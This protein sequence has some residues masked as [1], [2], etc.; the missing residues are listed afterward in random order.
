MA[1]S[2]AARCATVGSYAAG[3]A[4]DR[5]PQHPTFVG[6]SPALRAALRLIDCFAPHDS[7]P[8][9]I[10]GESGT[11]KS[12]AARALHLRSPRAGYVFHQ[13]ILAA[14]DD[15]LAASDLF[16]HLSGAYTDARQS[17]PGHFVSANGGTLFLDEI[18]KASAAVQRKLLHAVEHYE[19]WPVGADRAVR[20]NVRLVAATNV[21]LGQ[22]VTRGEFLPDLAARLTNFRIQLPALRE[23]REDI[24]DLVRQFVAMRAPRCGFPHRTP[25]VSDPLLRALQCADWPNNLRQLDALLQRLL[26][27]AEGADTLGLE[28]CRDDLAYL[29]HPPAGAVEK[30]GPLTREAIESAL[31][32]AGGNV[33]RA[34]ALLG[35]DRTT[36]HRK[37][38]LFA[39][40]HAVPMALVENADRPARDTENCEL[41]AAT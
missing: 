4:V 25:S 14:L 16:G 6:T 39:R 15:N 24:P 41:R 28:H 5:A 38:R 30:P 27:E 34:A 32:R 13:V 10:E 1:P 26:I 8:V 2:P 17:R 3:S 19:V 9:L 29:R 35:V 22:L 21:P 7:L 37:R 36:L 33:S 31:A 12:Y 20:L 23:R 18:G 11:G 40:E